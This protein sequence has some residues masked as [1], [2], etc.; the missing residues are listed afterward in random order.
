MES[1]SSEPHWESLRSFNESSSRL[2]AQW[3]VRCSLSSDLEWS[4][5]HSNHQTLKIFL[6]NVTW[7]SCRSPGSRCFP[8]LFAMSFHGLVLNWEYLQCCIQL[9]VW[10]WRSTFQFFWFPTGSCTWWWYCTFYIAGGRCTMPPCIENISLGKRYQNL[11]WPPLMGFLHCMKSAD[12]GSTK[13]KSWTWA[14]HMLW[15]GETC[16]RHLPFLGS[17]PSDPFFS[18]HIYEF[19]SHEFF[20]LSGQ[21]LGSHEFF[22]LLGQAL[23]ITE[24][25]DCQSSRSMQVWQQEEKSEW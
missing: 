13:G 11:E 9:K 3:L 21:A 16:R 5:H 15:R 14:P 18:L 22:P 2:H 25:E 24:F 20:P 6:A 8:P 19:P 17:S 1:S 4:V 10:K 7:L 12:H 23:G